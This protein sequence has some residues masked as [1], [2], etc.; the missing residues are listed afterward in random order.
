VR[1]IRHD[2]PSST[3]KVVVE[4]RWLPQVQMNATLGTLEFDHHITGVVGERGT[5]TP[6]ERK[7]K[8]LLGRVILAGR[9][10]L[11]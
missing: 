11:G 4:L 8:D 5:C 7:I 3:K 1:S 10:V 9:R 6:F 2:Y